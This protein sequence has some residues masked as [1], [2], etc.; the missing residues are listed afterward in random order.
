[1][2]NGFSLRFIRKRSRGS[3]KRKMRE[4]EFMLADAEQYRALL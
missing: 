2:E 4:R 3:L 1:M